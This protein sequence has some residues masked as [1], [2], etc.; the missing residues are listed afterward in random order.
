MAKM[1]MVLLTGANVFFDD[2]LTAEE[3]IENA[4]DQGFYTASITAPRASSEATVTFNADHIVSVGEVLQADA[5]G[6][7]LPVPGKFGL[8][9]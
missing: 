4:R 9:S 8:V 6:Q 5:P 1:E 3:I 2:V 7:I